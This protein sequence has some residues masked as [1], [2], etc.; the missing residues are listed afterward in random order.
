M[1]SLT[2]LI[3]QSGAQKG[4]SFPVG[5]NMTLGR[6]P[7]NSIVLQDQRVSRQHCEIWKENDNYKIRDLNSKNG[8]FVNNIRAKETI[9]L[10][11]SIIKIGDTALLFRAQEEKTTDEISLL[12][13]KTKQTVILSKLPSSKTQELRPELLEKLSSDKAIKNLSTIYHV[14]SVIYSIREID[15]LL[16]KVLELIFKTLPAERGVIF[17]YDDED[18]ELKPRTSYTEGGVSK[19]TIKVSFSIVN[20]AFNERVSILS[21]DAVS[22]KRFDAKKSIMREAIR[23]AM[24]VPILTHD[25]RFGVIYLDTQTQANAFNEDAMSLI[26]A[27]SSQVAI[28][29]ENIYFHKDLEKT[30]VTLHDEIKQEYNMIGVSKEIKEVFAQISRVA[31]TNSTVLISGES[32]TGK[33]LVARAIHYNGPRSNKPFICIN[34]TA[35]PETLIESELFGH[36]KGAF[37]GA[38]AA[39]PGQFE[40]ANGGTILLD[41][42]GEMP[43]GSQMKLL[44][45]LEENK[46]RR[47]GGT[48]DIPVYVRVIAA[49]NKNLDKAVEN[50]TFREDLYY[51]LKVINIQIAPLRER[52]EDIQPLIEYF[53][54]Q[55][56]TKTTYPVKGL[57]PEAIETMKKY[58]WPGNVRQLKNCLERGIIMCKKEFIEPKDLDLMPCEIPTEEKSK[59]R[60][61]ADVEKEHIIKTLAELNGNKTKAAE[62]LGIRRST[63]YEKLKLYS[64]E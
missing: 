34:C 44:R 41:E 64:I 27:I 1:P 30:A 35:L 22:D 10:S 50:N 31:Q 63:L 4:Q 61:I 43:T 49:S 23:S 15:K 56:K 16:E 42:I 21:A 11:N 3:V 47:I 48:R 12:S 9:L 29:I 5:D 58:Q 37:T 17:L 25:K 26:S 38:Y 28:A 20:E 46:V 55:F 7:S 6:D 62:V 53:L 8:T 36:E 60:T 33:E 59:P 57:S 24:C 52:K 45:V 32:G 39:K 19:N 40:L 18:M 2:K 51:R 13:P 14:S 54:N